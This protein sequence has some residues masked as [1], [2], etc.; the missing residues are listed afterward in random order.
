VC[1]PNT[2]NCQSTPVACT[3]PGPCKCA[4]Q[5][6]DTASDIG[7]C[8][9]C[10][11]VCA[12]GQSCVGG[13]CSGGTTETWCTDGSIPGQIFDSN[14]VGCPGEAP[15]SARASACTAGHHVC[16]ATEYMNHRSS[17]VPMYHY[18]VADSLGHAGTF[19]ACSVGPVG[20]DY[21]SCGASTSMLVCKPSLNVP[22]YDPA[23]NACNWSNCGWL[24]ASPNQ[25][26]GGCSRLN[27]AGTL[28]CSD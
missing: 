26:F 13:T 18:W 7:N 10:G 5:C 24:T 21:E 27:S 4:D 14:M 22:S 19:S 2:G 3:S 12:A 9:A 16:T 15:Y 6:V 28:C 23:G 8:G 25:Y 11:V 17:A 20:V 1:D